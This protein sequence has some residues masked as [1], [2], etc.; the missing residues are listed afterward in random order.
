[1]KIIRPAFI[2]RRDP[3]APFVD[4]L[5]IELRYGARLR[6]I[7]RLLSPNTCLACYGPGNRLLDLIPAAHP[8]V[9]RL[10]EYSGEKLRS[11]KILVRGNFLQ[12]LEHP[13]EI[14]PHDNCTE[15]FIRCGILP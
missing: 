12:H 14:T 13:F 11:I 8:D 2:M 9:F 6:F 4:H 7:L 3:F 1:M 10:V 15:D 5:E